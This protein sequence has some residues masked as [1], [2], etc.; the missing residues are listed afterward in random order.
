M[1]F[2]PLGAWQMY[3]YPL[4]CGGTRVLPLW[5][6]ECVCGSIVTWS[7][8]FSGGGSSCNPPSSLLLS[9]VNAPGT[10]SLSYALAR[11]GGTCW[12]FAAEFVGILLEQSLVLQRSE[13]HWLLSS[14][15]IRFP[16]SP[17]W[18]MSPRCGCGV[19]VAWR[20]SWE[21]VQDCFG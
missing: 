2:R 1:G 3:L 17:L 13:P 5:G 16:L 15:P 18:Q 11:E 19:L 12:L 9:W 6:R 4:L 20:R 14:V 7:M 10:F 21:G 8:V